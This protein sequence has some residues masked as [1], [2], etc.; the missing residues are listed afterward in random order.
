MVRLTDCPD[1]TLDVYHGCK[2]TIQQQQ[3]RANTPNYLF[4]EFVV[5]LQ[6]YLLFGLTDIH[7]SRF[8]AKTIRGLKTKA[9]TALLFRAFMSSSGDVEIRES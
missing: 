4:L 2:T 9:F 7:C 3:S 1:K 5:I 8:Y 6:W